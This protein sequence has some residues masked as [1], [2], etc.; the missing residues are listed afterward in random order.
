MTRSEDER[1]VP[2]E[3]GTLVERPSA[4]ALPETHRERAGVDV[5]ADTEVLSSAGGLARDPLVTVTVAPAAASNHDASSASVSGPSLRSSR[6]TQLD[7]RPDAVLRRDEIERTRTIGRLGGMMVLAGALAVPFL[8]GDPTA[9]VILTIAMIGSLLASGFVL[10]I[11]AE[12]DRYSDRRI[13]T[14]WWI[15]AFTNSACFY[16]FGAF[17]PAPIV[18][19]LVL[20]WVALAHNRAAAYAFYAVVAVAQAGIAGLIIAG[21]IADR[22]V[23]AIGAVERTDQVVIQLLVQL[24]LFVALLVGFE[25]RRTTLRKVQEMGEAVKAIAQ[26]ELLLQEARRDLER[27]LRSRPEGRFTGHRLGPFL[28]GSVI[29][30]G[31]MGEVYDA[32]HVGTGEP[33]A[34]KLLQLEGLRSPER[35]RRFL[36]E[37][38]MA[39]SVH[40]PNI[41]R[42]LEIGDES[43]EFPYLAMERLDGEDLGQWM[44]R[45][46][47]RLAEVLEMLQQIGEGITAAKAAG[48]VH[49]DLKPSNVFRATGPSGTAVWKILDFGVSKQEEHDGTLT[50]GN[51]VGTPAYMAP[52]Q[53]QQ[54]D[55]DHRADLY[56]LAAIAYRAFT[57]ARP[58]DARDIPKLLHDVV[59][60]MPVRPSGLREVP[61][62]LDLVLAIGMA[63]RPADRFG[64]ASELCDA[65]AAALDGKLAAALRA[66]GDHLLSLLPWR[67]PDDQPAA[68]VTPTDSPRPSR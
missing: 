56:A 26:R 32:E 38:A 59:Y 16:Y 44:R 22:G 15:H 17:S 1:T 57:G 42:V 48:I 31:G 19:V 55:V 60:Q 24:V 13:A 4:R 2:D 49:R 65:I 43:A 30:R 54:G 34:I 52:E 9:K 23:I 7:Y 47:P 45:R 14:V 62:D 3:I 12:P 64:S 50:Q 63:K 53:A 35:A 20:Y 61:A 28:L 39:A 51:L 5:A 67:E 66:R 29:G 11:T 25:S 8:N 33:A 58:F 68:V 10:Y 18:A 36:R 41:V 40:A 6:L 27:A 46:T 37:L 21:Q